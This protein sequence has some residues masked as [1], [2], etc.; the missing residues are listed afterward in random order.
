[1]WVIK[2]LDK[3]ENISEGLIYIL[4]P[5]KLVDKVNDISDYISFEEDGF[6]FIEIPPSN[7]SMLNEVANVL[8]SSIT[9]EGLESLIQTLLLLKTQGEVSVVR[10]VFELSNIFPD[11]YLEV[12]VMSKFKIIVRLGDF[13]EVLLNKERSEIDEKLLRS[14]LEPIFQNPDEELFRIFVLNN[15]LFKIKGIISSKFIKYFP[16]K[17]YDLGVYAVP[18]DRHIIEEIREKLIE[19]VHILGSVYKEDINF[20]KVGVYASL[21]RKNCLYSFNFDK[22]TI[23]YIPPLEECNV[24]LN[25]NEKYLLDSIITIFNQKVQKLSEM[26]EEDGSVIKKM[27]Y[28]KF[29][30]M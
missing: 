28:K 27:I 19:N 3:F 8:L 23:V 2:V 13:R 14:V 25:N 24:H 17:L 20:E 12:S 18:K 5:K 4:L 11:F 22:Y 9:S 15:Y 30:L 10:K 16:D 29:G 6:Y 26:L 7:V 1:M 21:V